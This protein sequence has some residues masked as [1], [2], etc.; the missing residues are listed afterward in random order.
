MVRLMDAGSH[1]DFRLIKREPHETGPKKGE[2]RRGISIDQVRK[3]QELFAVAPSL[4]DWRV[5]VIDCMDELEPQ[6]AQALLKILEE[7]PAKSVFLLVA[8]APGRLLPTIRSRCRRLDFATLDAGSMDAIL[9]AE[10]PKLSAEER[11][12]LIPLAGGSVGRAIDFAELD[13]GPLAEEALAILRHG[14]PDNARRSRLASSLALKAA[15][16]RYA[17]FLDMVPPL[18]AAEARS[19]EGPRR[20]RAAEAYERARETASLAPRLS[21]DP[22]A[23]IFSLGTIMAGVGEG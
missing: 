9:G 14:D 10:R 4:G 8:H 13:L 19:A 16:A 22:A 20:L 21:L 18:L 6:A 2:L 3:L 17:A 5:A 12:R 11:S 7:P 15:A 23:T 1:P